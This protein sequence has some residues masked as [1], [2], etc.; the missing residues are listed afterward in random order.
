MSSRALRAA[1]ALLLAGLILSACG[2]EPLVPYSTDTPPL[3]LA[4]ANQAGVIDQRGRFREIYCAVLEE[5]PA[6]IDHRPCE[7]AL[8][9]VGTEPPGTGQPVNL[10][11]SQRH[12]IAAIVP[13]LGYGCFEDWLA[14]TRSVAE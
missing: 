1:F 9:R 4:P 3:V 10:G 12:L 13:G 5:N 14:L 7:E 8:T 6:A 2:S 11:I